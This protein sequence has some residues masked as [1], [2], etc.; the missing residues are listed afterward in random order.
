VKNQSN[1][2]ERTPGS[3]AAPADAINAIRDASDGVLVELA[4]QF[5]GELHSA[6][7][8]AALLRGYLTALTRHLELEGH[9]G[10]AVGEAQGAV[11]RSIPTGP[12]EMSPSAIEAAV[13]QWRQLADQLM[14]DATAELVLPGN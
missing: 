8:R 3:T 10:R 11:R 4:A 1:D 7:R 14:S 13:A 5:A 9:R 2:F 6:E 12:F